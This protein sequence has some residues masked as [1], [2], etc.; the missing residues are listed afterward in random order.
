MYGFRI[1]SDVIVSLSSGQADF[2][3]LN[4]WAAEI[5]SRLYQMIKTQETSRKRKSRARFYRRKT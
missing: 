4:A 3:G 5:N 2:T 1:F